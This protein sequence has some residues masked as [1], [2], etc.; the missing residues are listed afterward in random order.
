[1][2]LRCDSLY[3]FPKV[4]PVP[5]GGSWCRVV[6]VGESWCW[7]V[8]VGARRCQAVRVG[9]SQ[10][11]LVESSEIGNVGYNPCGS[12]PDRNRLKDIK[13]FVLFQS[14]A[15]VDC[16]SHSSTLYAICTRI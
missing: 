1:M 13:S 4:N 2:S 11:R 9:E 7:V 5:T 12:V 8:P 3:T 16:S 6:P 15:L 14:F 10:Y